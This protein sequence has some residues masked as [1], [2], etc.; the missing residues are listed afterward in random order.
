LPFRE[1]GPF[2]GW[3]SAA[4]AASVGAFAIVN[5]RKKSIHWAGFRVFGYL[6]AASFTLYIL[7]FSIPLKLF[8]P[9]RYVE[10]SL[11]LFYCL[12][13]ALCLRIVIDSLNMTRFVFPALFLFLA[14]LG[15]V[16]L[17][18][19]D[20]YDY[21]ADAGLYRFLSTTPLDVTIAGPPEVMDN[22]LTF[23]RR[24]A[25][26]TYELS[27][28]W[29]E[30]Y[31]SVIKQRS[32]DFF[33]AYYSDDAEQIRTFCKRNGIGYI[34]VREEDFSGEKLKKG[35]VYFEPFG[36]FISE[37]TLNRSRFA[38]L[39]DGIF[40]AVFRTEGFRVVKVELL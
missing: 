26:V 15:A 37:I 21:S 25:F 18:N 14:L 10:Y 22:V 13:F 40:P 12:A 7:A 31:W 39:D 38:L 16:R 11:T 36:S 20:L 33:S 9:G 6:M 1:W 30:P 2:C 23:S 32:F 28:T 5:A 35:K 3:M 19:V 24:K 4:V 27:H 29:I 17:H 34:V 8:I